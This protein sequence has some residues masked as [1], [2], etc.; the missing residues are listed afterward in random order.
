MMGSSQGHLADW[1]V[2]AK[3]RQHTQ[4]ILIPDNDEAGKKYI[5]V[6]A[7]EIQKACPKAE[8]LVCELPY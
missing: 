2:L 1:Y 5:G 8:L 3:Y 6:V 4:F 7:K